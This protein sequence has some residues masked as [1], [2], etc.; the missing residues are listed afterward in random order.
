MGPC[1]STARVDGTLTALMTIG[2]LLFYRGMTTTGLS[3]RERRHAYVA[4]VVRRAHER[5]GGFVLPG[6]RARDRGS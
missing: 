3:R 1:A 6:P 4:L 2:T 5:A